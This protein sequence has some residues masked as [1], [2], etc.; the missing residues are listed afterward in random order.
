MKRAAMDFTPPTTTTK[1][2][3]I[4]FGPQIATL[5]QQANGLTDNLLLTSALEDPSTNPLLIT[6]IKQQ[7]QMMAVVVQTLALMQAQF[8]QSAPAKTQTTV[9][10][11]LNEVRRA[12]CLVLSNVEE[13]TEARPIDRVQ[14][15]KETVLNILSECQLDIGAPTNIFRMGRSDLG[16]RRLIKVEL[17]STAAVGQVLR[18][19]NKLM[20]G[21]YKHVRIRRSMT[22]EQIRARSDLIE[23]C[24]R[25]RNETGFDFIIYAN[26]IMKREEV[27]S[28]RKSQQQKNL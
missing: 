4:D 18:N 1:K 26:V 8:M 24:K 17:P 6:I 12:H 16:R 10:D 21:R 20:N 7:Q 27:P 9:I 25:K 13:S 19:A 14:K 23:E 2:S 11:E 22:A 5:I 28:F 15:D 3:M